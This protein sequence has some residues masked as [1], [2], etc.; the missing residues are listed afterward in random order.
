MLHSCT[1]DVDMVG[2]TVGVMS[3]DSLHFI[4][5]PIQMQIQMWTGVF[6]HS[7]VC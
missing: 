4:N 2:D 3:S 7:L 6:N 5:I 1:M